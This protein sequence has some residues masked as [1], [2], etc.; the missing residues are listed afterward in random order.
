MCR[1]GLESG[2]QSSSSWGAL[3]EVVF[4]G[5]D[6]Q[7]PLVCDPSVYTLWDCD[8]TVCPISDNEDEKGKAEMMRVLEEKWY[9]LQKINKISQE[10]VKEEEKQTEISD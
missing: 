3:S 2:F 10:L 4:M 6:I 1:Y 7:L 5:D 9:T 8:I